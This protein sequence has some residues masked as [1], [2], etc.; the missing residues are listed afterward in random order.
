MGFCCLSTEFEYTF[1][2]CYWWKWHI[3]RNCYENVEKNAY[4]YCV[5]LKMWFQW[6]QHLWRYWEA[7]AGRAAGEGN[8]SSLSLCICVPSSLFSNTI[9]WD[10]SYLPLR[11]F[12]D[13]GWTLSCSLWKFLTSRHSLVRWLTE[14]TQWAECFSQLSLVGSA[15]HHP[16]SLRGLRWCLV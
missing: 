1:V 10:P 13:S 4:T 11:D 12:G 6:S 5:A 8:M 16:K 14:S 15:P 3:I 9:L 7:A 2:C